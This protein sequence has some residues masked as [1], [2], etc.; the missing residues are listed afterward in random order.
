MR[1][2][3]SRGFPVFLGGFPFGKILQVEE[4]S[5]REIIKHR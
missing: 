3:G 1:R 5:K 2:L 4:I